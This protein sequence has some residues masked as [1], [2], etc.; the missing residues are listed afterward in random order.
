LTDFLE[1]VSSDGR[2]VL[3]ADLGDEAPDVW[4]Q[5]A[6]ERDAELLW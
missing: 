1:A 5:Q 3:E 2:R 4:I 6:R